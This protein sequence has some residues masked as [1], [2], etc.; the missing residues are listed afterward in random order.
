MKKLT[1]ILIFS[2]AVVFI[3]CLHAMADVDDHIFGPPTAR[4]HGMVL[5]E[6]INDWTY[7]GK[8]AYKIQV[9]K[10]LEKKDDSN[11]EENYICFVRFDDVSLRRFNK[12]D[13][14]D[15]LAFDYTRTGPLQCCGHLVLSTEDASWNGS[16]IK[17]IGEGDDDSENDEETGDDL[18]EINFLTPDTDLVFEQHD[19]IKFDVSVDV[20]IENA[21]EA[22]IEIEFF[23]DT[24]TEYDNFNH[25]KLFSNSAPLDLRSSAGIKRVF[26]DVNDQEWPPGDYHILAVVTIRTSPTQTHT[27]YQYG[28][29]IITIAESIQPENWQDV[30]TVQ[31]ITIESDYFS[32]RNKD[33]RNPYYD[34]VSS[35]VL[36]WFDTGHKEAATYGHAFFV[37]I[38]LNNDSDRRID[39]I[40]MAAEFVPQCD[41]EMPVIVL[42]KV[43]DNMVQ[44]PVGMVS[45]EPGINRFFIVHP[46]HFKVKNGFVSHVFSTMVTSTGNTQYFVPYNLKMKMKT[47]SEDEFTVMGDYDGSSYRHENFSYAG[48]PNNTEE[49][50]SPY[51][52]H[53]VN[54]SRNHYFDSFFKMYQVKPPLENLMAQADVCLQGIWYRYRSPDPENNSSDAL[55]DLYEDYSENYGDEI[56]AGIHDKNSA[57][58]KK[59]MGFKRVLELIMGLHQDEMDVLNSDSYEQSISEIQKAVESISRGI[60]CLLGS[61]GFSDDLDLCIARWMSC[62]EKGTT[63]YSNVLEYVNAM[64][65]KNYIDNCQNSRR[66]DCEACTCYNKEGIEIHSQPG[67]TAPHAVV[68]S[69]AAPNHTVTSDSDERVYGT[70]SSKRI[71]V[72][73]GARAELLYF[74]G[75]NVIQ[76]QSSSELFT[77]CRS[78]AFVTFRGTDDTVLKLA[79]TTDAQTLAFSN[80]KRVTL[81]VYN[82]QVMLDDQ[83]ITAA[84]APIE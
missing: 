52:I 81:M 22:G 1:D 2:L 11:L 61:Q 30:V 17:K 5:E 33:K 21:M 13:I 69:N 34:S 83:V 3:S 64:Y 19:L 66:P 26:R 80:D 54:G 67:E 20:I 18:L 58:D 82:N 72:E 47:Q 10:V 50:R 35:Y 40:L 42:N 70:P 7:C 78:G 15:I 48:D 65:A 16:F 6:D 53:F 12:N 76:I 24:D 63:G 56:Q 14:V 44:A 49:P 41:C 57:H 43:T 36:P 59:R 79:A 4:V 73:S 55:V 27:V 60:S 46:D 38:S 84:A 62:Y 32:S 51:V 31:N 77:V 37:S 68:M 25:Q 39:N 9:L 75:Q 74:P 71:V 23:R 8:Y 29:G 45:L 28:P